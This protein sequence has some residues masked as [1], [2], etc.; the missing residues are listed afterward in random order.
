MLSLNHSGAKLCD[1]L[2]RREWLRIGGLSAFGVGLPQL[3]QTRANA[4]EPILASG[5]NG[6]F[7]KA[8]S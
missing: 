2:S 4:V 6:S 8:K 5:L 7:G 1:G 3:M